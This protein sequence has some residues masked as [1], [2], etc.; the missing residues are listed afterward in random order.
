[1]KNKTQ[2]QRV[3]TKLLRDGFITR[4]EALRNFISRLS[5]IIQDLEAEGWEF[6][7]KN[8]GGDY[9]YTIVKSPYKLVTRTLSNGEQIKSYEI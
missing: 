3:E 2:K 7:T 6:D 5:A 4:N 1:M 9:I 8:K